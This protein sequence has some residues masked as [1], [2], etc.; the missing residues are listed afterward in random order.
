MYILIRLYVKHNPSNAEKHD[1]ILRMGLADG[2][3]VWT[4]P[5][6][7]KHSG[8]DPSVRRRAR[9]RPLAGKARH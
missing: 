8:P 5:L 1:R 7:P 4:R 3:T 6:A 2:S 9:S